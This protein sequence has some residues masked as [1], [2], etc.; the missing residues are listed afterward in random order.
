MP[1]RTINL[2]MVLGKKKE[3]ADLR[4]AL[5][6]THSE[7]NKAVEKI[8]K[9]LLLCRGRSYFTLN[10]KEEVIEIPESQV[11]QEALQMAREAQK[12][13]GEN[14]KGKKEEVL[15]LLRK[16]YEKII[17]SCVL[18]EKENP[19]KGD[20]QASNAWVSPLMDPESQGGLSVFEKI[21]DPPPKWIKKKE[22]GKEGWEKA[23]IQWLKT[24]EAR[25]L[26]K[27]PGSPPAWVRKLRNDQPW[28]DA[29]IE[30]QKKKL[31]EVESGNAPVIKELKEMGLLPLLSPILRENLE[32]E[33]HGVNVWDRLT[34][35]LAVAHLL[36]W[37]SWNHST[38]K[39]FESAREKRDSL[40]SEF[41]KYDKKFEDIRKYELAR[42]KELKK[43]AMA[44]DNRPYRI[45]V[46]SIRGWDKI[47]PMWL[48][49][50]DTPEKRKEILADFQ[51]RH[52]GQYGDPSLYLWLAEKGRE[53]LW[54]D[55]NVLT[56]LVKLNIAEKQLDKRRPYSLMTFAEG[57]KHP[58]WAMYEAPGGSNLRNYKLST[59]KN[60]LMVELPLLSRD[61]TGK[62]VEQDFQIRLAPSGQ[63]SNPVFSKNG[64]KLFL[65]YQSA[66][67][68]FEGAPGGAE[69]LLDRPYLENQ[70]LDLIKNGLVGPVWLKL[71]LDVQSKAPREWL[72]GK[73]RVSTPSEVHHFKTS[74]YNKSKHEKK[75]KP[76]LR[77]LSV[78][79]GMRT[80]ASCSVFEL[81]QGRPKK[82]FYFP[83]ADGRE[84]K[85]SKKLWARHER[86]FKLTLPGENPSKKERELRQK[87]IDEIRSIRRDINK[88]KNILQLSVVENDEERSIKI[89]KLL[90]SAVQDKKEEKNK[91]SFA[92][93][94]KVLEGLDDKKMRSTPQL[95]QK[96]CQTIYDEAEKVVAEKF[97][98]WRKET[99]PR[100][101]SWEEWRK[102]RGY[103]GGKS[104][105]M[106]EYLESVR[107]LILS[108]NLRGRAYGEIKRQ[109][110]K[111]Q[112]T[113]AAGLLRHIN[114]LKKDRTKSGADLIIQAARGYIPDKQGVGWV[115][116]FEPCRLILFED[117]ARYRFRVD[118]PRRENSQLMKWNHREIINETEL[119]GQIYGMVVET[120]AAGFSSRYL[121]SNGCPG[122]RCRYLSQ[123]DF[124]GELPKPY[125]VYE[126]DWILG[127]SKDNDF[128]KK[129][130]ALSQR[131]KPGMW[132][133]WHGGELFSSLNSEKKLHE[134]HADI[135]AAQN[136]QRRFWSRCGEAYRIYCKKTAG[137]DESLYELEKKPGVRLA[138]ALM[139]L[140]NGDK[141]FYLKEEDGKNC[142]RMEAAGKKKLKTSAQDGIDSMEEE[143]EEQI[144]EIEEEETS[145]SRMTFFRDPSGRIF[146]SKYWIPS[147]IYWSVVRNK[148]WEAMNEDGGVEIDSPF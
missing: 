144:S 91:K 20:A 7:I 97:S 82:G 138:G 125:V 98:E 57:R 61:E 70:H 90:N 28:Q 53:S 107:K 139:Q 71:T 47:R 62:L 145:K 148:V 26:Q 96:H 35:R 43:V 119:Q 50:G 16:L 69:I 79:L 41:K 39:E 68:E 42:H 89:E 130:L 45:G 27:T 10:E 134:I 75:L 56:P 65:K 25:Q 94:E 81:V 14:N 4:R 5:W 77:V 136:L 112:G 103:H 74:L 34:M 117:L 114:N 11:K 73:G 88:L 33:G 46:R 1:T 135:N 29:F 110:R 123:D 86:S 142:F 113:V 37:E 129:Q 140:E 118:R 124:E 141:E 127:Y 95:W 66:H 21:I 99:R 109:S 87:A 102:R 2:K 111:E 13:N 63:L 85:D 17:P 120:T 38:K 147:K 122:V 72:D 52:R 106:L 92:I 83:A 133:P 40:K 15:L 6:T 58:R 132:V 116:K 49:K 54:K 3:T 32:P 30:D 48:E 115:K 67:Q 146:N 84:D 55:E 23:S 101:K 78:D 19:L 8:E 80:F 105:W 137:A 64:K 131:L 104:I 126:M 51:T 9:T 128:A 100:V 22:K 12:K 36:S 31:K 60:N 24:E 121:A 76:G 59:I 44:D 93:T 143:M 108:W 18:D